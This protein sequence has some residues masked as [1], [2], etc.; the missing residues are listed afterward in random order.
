MKKILLVLTLISSACTMQQPTNTM[1][2]NTSSPTI[3]PTAS[4]VPTANP[5]VAPTIVS[6][7]VPFT[8]N[9]EKEYKVNMETSLGNIQLRL[10]KDT[11]KTVENFVRLIDKKY[12]DGVTFHRVIPGFMIQGGDPTGS[13]NG[14]DSI[15]GGDFGDEFRDNLKFTKKGLL[16]M[17][18]RGPNTNTSQFFITVDSYRYP[19]N[20][21]EN[22]HTIF[23][24][25]TEGFDVL[26]KIATT[27]RNAQDKPDTPVV[28]NK[29]TLY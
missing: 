23:G 9:P 25:V 2:S 8:F 4:V 13:G 24:E 10:Y 3:Q 29:V 7:P 1:P 17:A 12:Y 6:T 5:S 22:K 18:N 16:A 20:F 21:L 15:Y 26:E 11:P 27:P 28:M 14:G 19:F